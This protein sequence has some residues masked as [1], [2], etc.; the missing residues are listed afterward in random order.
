MKKSK[1]N[2]L[3]FSHLLPI[4]GFLDFWIIGNLGKLSIN[5][6]RNDREL[7]KFFYEKGFCLENRFD[8]TI[9]RA[10]EKGP[11]VR[12]F[13]KNMETYLDDF[14]LFE[15]KLIFLIEEFLDEA[16]WSRA[17]RFSKKLDFFKMVYDDYNVD[18]ADIFEIYQRILEGKNEV[19]LDAYECPPRNKLKKFFKR[20][21][22]SL[23]YFSSQDRLT[24]KVHNS[25]K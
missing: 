11:Y 24:I 17:K 9:V 14:P 12:T 10:F 1:K 4:F 6:D 15:P 18:M 23:K 2:T 22:F 16:R 13:I 20:M 5:F 7:R 21:G 3:I 19:S 25:S 8:C